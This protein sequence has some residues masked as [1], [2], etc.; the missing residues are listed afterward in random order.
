M[1]G[2]YGTAVTIE[3]SPPRVPAESPMRRILREDNMDH[4]GVEAVVLGAS[5]AGLLTAKVLAETHDRVTVVERDSLTGADVAGRKG[6]PQSHHAHVLLPRGV[7]VLDELFPGL[8]DRM[9]AD[10]VP[11]HR[12]GPETWREVR[13][14]VMCRTGGPTAAAREVQPSRPYL[15]GLIREQVHG[16]PNVVFRDSCSAL[17]PVTDRSQ[18]RVIGA[19]VAPQDGEEE[20]L[21][22]DLVVD[23]TGRSGLTAKWLPQLG[24][25]PPETD[26]VAVDVMY[27]SR[28]VRLRPDALG[29]VQ[30]VLI[31]ATP[32]RPQVMALFE[33][34]DD[35]FTLTVGGY[36]DHH[37]PADHEGFLRF[38]R[39]VSPQ[40]IITALRDAEWLDDV[41]RHRFPS[42]RRRRYERLR[43]FP[44]GLLVLGDG[45]CSFDP[46]LGQGMTVAAL[47]AVALR[48]CLAEGREDLPRRFFAAASAVID[49]PWQQ[50]VNN[51]HVQLGI[52]QPSGQRVVGVYIDAL[53]AAAADD[54]LLAGRLFNVSGLIDPPAALV[55]PD[56]ALRVLAGILRRRLRRGHHPGQ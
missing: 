36:T 22:A 47:Q 2:A 49:V 6:V 45:I 40:F 11:F 55:R 32:A 1:S 5:I 3:G 42:S 7:L 21:H 23:A 50:A 51:A 30:L 28:R 24:Y 53:I 10:G 18:D 48:E 9:T 44:D 41:R 39:S 13:G 54:P 43:R 25:T 19:R 37:P 20:I 29:G 4:S 52:P 34:E 12:G 31:G 38:L 27:A 26:E 8:I 46:L 17:A 33:Q 15:E 16:L 14:H 35:F 56:V